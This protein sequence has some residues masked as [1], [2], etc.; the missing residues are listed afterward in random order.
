MGQMSF[1]NILRE[2]CPATP[3]VVRPLRQALERYIQSIGL[4]AEQQAAVVT[5]F[6]EAAANVITH[7]YPDEPGEIHVT[8]A[9]TATELRVRVADDGIGCNAPSARPGLGLGLGLMADACST[10]E[11]Q[12]R[13]RGGTMVTMHFRID[14][15]S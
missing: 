12:E 11:L 14:P 5:A 7:A 4:D 10:L 1:A 15:R 9:A 8:A 2:S 6:S 13:R 3:E